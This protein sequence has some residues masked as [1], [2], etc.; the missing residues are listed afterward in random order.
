MPWQESENRDVLEVKITKKHEDFEGGEY[1]QMF[2]VEVV[3]QM[4]TYIK[5][6]TLYALNMC[7]LL[8]N[9]YGSYRCLKIICI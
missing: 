5:L 9:N 2:I 7:S 6:V 8:Y 4:D 1:I 3:L